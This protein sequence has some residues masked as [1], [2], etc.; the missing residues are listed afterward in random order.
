MSLSGDTGHEVA[1]AADGRR[2]FVPIYSNAAVGAS[3]SDGRTIDVVD[4]E[5]G[6]LVR[7]HD[8]GRPVRPHC[9]VSGGDGLL[10]LTA[11][12]AQQVLLLE[13]DSLSLVASVPTG[14]AE[15]HM[16]ALS[17]DR[18]IACTANVGPGTVSVLDI[19]ARSLR[20]VVAVCEKV[21]RVT[22]SPDGR[23]AFTADQSAPRLAVIDTAAL[24]VRDWIPLPGIGFGSALTSDGLLVVALRS[25]SAVAIVDTARPDRIVVVAVPAG[26][27]AIILDDSQ[28][29]AFTACHVDEVV[30]E[31][32]LESANVTKVIRVG[33]NPDGLC[34][35]GARGAA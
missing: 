9:A 22:L 14:A 35:I 11:E 25:T 32:D 4:V 15:S 18:A 28:R 19:T 34:W 33:R 12:T 13:E 1:L 7:T 16:L 31:I 20:G 26:P 29:R 24:V 5:A 30:V 3:G 2:A 6:T 8:L 10:Y 23:W 21:N 27:Q 17:A